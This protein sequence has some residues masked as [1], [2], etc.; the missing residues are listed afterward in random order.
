MNQQVAALIEATMVVE[1]E[2]A[3]WAWRRKR[4]H[5]DRKSAKDEERK[6]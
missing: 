2:V 4:K 1:A 5:V 3:L 6:P